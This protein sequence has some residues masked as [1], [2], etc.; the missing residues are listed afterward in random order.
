MAGVLPGA[1]V[2]WRLWG[3]L[4]RQKNDNVPCA[5]FWLKFINLA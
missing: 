5:V 3:W 4:L 1:I 2:A